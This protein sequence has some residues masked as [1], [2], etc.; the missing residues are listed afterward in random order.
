MNKKIWLGVLV[1]ALIGVTFYLLRGGDKSIYTSDTTVR[2]NY[3]IATD[4]HIVLKNNA[5]LTVEGDM[6]VDGTL[7]CDGG[8]LSLVVLGKLKVNG[9]LFCALDGHSTSVVPNM[10]IAITSKHIEFTKQAEVATNGHVVI[11]SEANDAL[12]SRESVERVWGETEEDTG[13]GARIGPFVAHNPTRKISTSVGDDGKNPEAEFILRGNWHIGDGAQLSIGLSVPTIPNNIPLD[14][15]YV[16]AGAQGALT[17]EDLTFSGPLGSDGTDD[18]NTSCAAK[19]QD[20]ALGARFRAHARN[21]SID[22]TSIHLGSGGKGGKGETKSDC[23]TATAVGGSGGSPG[24]IKLTAVNSLAV[25]GLIITPGKGGSGGD[26]HA[27]GKNGI[28][29]CPA[30]EGGSASAIAGKG[31]DNKASLAVAGTINSIDNISIGRVDG[32]RGGGAYAQGGGGGNGNACG[33]K[34][35]AGGNASAKGGAGGDT[36]VSLPHGTAEAHGGDG[37]DTTARAGA[38]GTGGSCADTSGVGEVEQGGVG[39]DGGKG[40]AMAGKG[41]V[42]TT[43]RGD[44]GKTVDRSGGDGGKGGDACSPGNGGQ[45]GLGFPVGDNGHDGTALCASATTTIIAP[46][47]I[48]MI[49]AILFHNK[50]L[51]IDQLMTS[52]LSGCGETYWHSIRGQVTATDGSVVTDTLLACDFGK[53][54]ETAVID[55]LKQVATATPTIFEVR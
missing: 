3:A 29:G 21:I 44:N 32:G 40:D 19:G 41:G 51:P 55:T 46:S 17:L 53:V 9:S 37:G 15:F 23:V 33:C 43:A 16:N 38:G 6:T 31:S 10:A 25:K 22:N 26:A 36:L 54:K 24:N 27:I 5:R 1:V 11:V 12:E 13:E 47:T 49:K 2:G 50:Y 30:N 7:S 39:G 18:K 14:L 34:G 45:G 35:G 8:S 28:D 48:P 42:G 52:D 4:K 20:G